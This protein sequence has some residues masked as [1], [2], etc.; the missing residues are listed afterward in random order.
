MQYKSDKGAIATI[1]AT[2][3]NTGL[4]F[5]KGTQQS[6]ITM[7]EDFISLN[8][9]YYSQEDCRGNIR[10][11]AGSIYFDCNDIHGVYARFK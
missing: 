8:A 4:N 10:F 1:K 7:R 5:T 2:G 3:I 11:R 6:F 9:E